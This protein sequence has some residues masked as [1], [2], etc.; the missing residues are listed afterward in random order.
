MMKLSN[1]AALVFLLTSIAAIPALAEKG[2]TWKLSGNKLTLSSMD[3]KILKTIPID[4]SNQGAFAASV[5][6][7]KEFA[8][9]KT[10]G[11]SRFYDSRGEAKWEGSG[12]EQALVSDDAILIITAGPAGCSSE[13]DP[14]CVRTLFTINNRGDEL[15][16]FSSLDTAH[17][18][19]VSPNQR[20]VIAN[21][22][23]K[24]APLKHRYLMFDIARSTINVEMAVLPGAPK[25]S[26]DGLVEFLRTNYGP[27]GKDGFPTVTG[28]E[29][30]SSIRIK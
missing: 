6:P 29:V 2:N 13:Y 25:V 28:S 8:V 20:F 22:L 26:N 17:I 4:K 3:G 16:R 27:P 21:I 19:G 1:L 11:L 15:L 10:K 18:N 24:I 30:I 5:S 14:P 7:N 23:P 9:G 12:V